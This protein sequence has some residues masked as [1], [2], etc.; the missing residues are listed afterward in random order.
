MN[1]LVQL[2]I[3]VTVDDSL[4]GQTVTWANAFQWWAE[5]KSVRGHEEQR[6]GRTASIET[7]L[8]VGRFDPRITTQHRAIVDG[9]TLNIRSATDRDGRRRTMTVEGEA[10]VNT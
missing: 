6:Q 2:Q 10:G 4:G 3:A 5:M 7:Y 8:L 9:K 1:H